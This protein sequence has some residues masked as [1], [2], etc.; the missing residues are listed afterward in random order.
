MR[1][2]RGDALDDAHGRRDARCAAADGRL[3]VY[4]LG[5]LDDAAGAR[6]QARAARQRGG[7]G[8]GGGRE[9]RRGGGQPFVAH[10]LV[11]RHTFLRVPSGNDNVELINSSWVV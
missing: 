8:R 3:A 10:R 11:G 5:G 6:A 2:R 7:H 4:G 9:V 1:R